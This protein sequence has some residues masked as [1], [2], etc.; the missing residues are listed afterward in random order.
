RIAYARQFFNDAVLTYNNAVHSFPSVIFASIFKFK[1][2]EFFE[3]TDAE[4]VAPKVQ[5]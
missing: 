5:F 2:S 4:K 3:A 1:E